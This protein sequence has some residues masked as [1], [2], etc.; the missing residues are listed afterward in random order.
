MKISRAV[1]V[2]AE[3]APSK[4]MAL[5]IRLLQLSYPSPLAWVSD[6]LVVVVVRPMAGVI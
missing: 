4:E 6:P 3:A 1:L 5:M 2:M